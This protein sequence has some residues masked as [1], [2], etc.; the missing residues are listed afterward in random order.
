MKNQGTAY[1]FFVL[2]GTLSLST[3]F[4]RA[5]KAKHGADAEAREAARVIHLF[6]AMPSACVPSSPTITAITTATDILPGNV[7]FEAVFTTH[8]TLIACLCA[9]EGRPCQK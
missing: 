1:I 5:S 8:I 6:A 9:T 2:A 7:S 3:S 4:A